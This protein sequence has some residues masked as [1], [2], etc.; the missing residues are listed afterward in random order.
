MIW[1]GVNQ[2]LFKLRGVKLKFAQITGVNRILL[3]SQGAK[4]AMKVQNK[5]IFKLQ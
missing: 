5:K 4:F 2:N 3:K 1:H